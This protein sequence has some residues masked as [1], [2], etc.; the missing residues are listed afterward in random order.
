MN[1]DHFEVKDFLNDP[2][3]IQ[4]VKRPD[5]ASQAYWQ[6]W[7]AQYPEK[8]YQIEEARQLALVLDF[9]VEVPTVEE[10]L[11]VKKAIKARLRNEFSDPA[12]NS[13][14]QPLGKPISPF[15][16]Y[17]LVAAT[18]AGVVLCSVLYF[19]LF[20]TEGQVVYH[21]S[22]GNTR[23][24]VL[25]DQSL[26]ILNANSTLHFNKPWTPDKPRVVWLS[27]EAF[28]EVRKKLSP[29]TG[30]PSLPSSK[31]TVHTS[32][33]DIQVLGTQ[34]NVQNRSGRVQVLLTS[35]KVKLEMPAQSPTEVWMKPGELAEVS[36]KEKAI[37]RRTVDPDRY[38]AWRNHQ[39]VFDETSVGDVARTIEDYY[40]VKVNCQ[41]PLLATKRFTGSVPS[42]NL[43]VLL[44]VL[45]ESFDLQITRKN[46][47]IMM[48]SKQ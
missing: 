1:Y 14:E 11:E 16:R 46:N 30:T 43:Q 21:T 36:G 23:T 34:F 6:A 42:N 32:T 8:A 20:A 13:D 37:S 29:E 25:P 31:F 38:L 22:Y 26:V 9:S 5:A 3:F 33:V 7:L 35:G 24:I 2:S 12:G 47:E 4:W 28:F 10:A 19:W 48:K 15:K 39:L 44:T 27:G 41:D 45:A 18:L 17:Y 40:G